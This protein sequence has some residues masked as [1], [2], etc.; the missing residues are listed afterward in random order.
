MTISK[1][2]F[3]WIF[4]FFLAFIGCE[5][6]DPKSDEALITSF[7]LSSVSATIAGEA[8]TLSVPYGTDISSLSPSIQNSTAS[9]ITPA[10]ATARNFGSP[11][12]YTVTA[13]D[14][15]TTNTYTVTVTVLDP[16]SVAISTFSIPDTNTQIDESAKTI[17]VSVFE[18]TD[19]S[20]LSPVI[21]TI[22]TD[23]TVMGGAILDL[24]SGP[25]TITVS[26]GSKSENYTVSVK[27]LS[28]GFDAENPVT[29]IDA[30]AA[31]NS[32]PTE[33]GDKGDNE[34]GFSINSQHVYVADKGEGVI[35]Y[36][37]LDGSSASASQLKNSDI[38]SGG[39]F[40]LA[41]VVATENGILASNMNW[42]GGE[43]KVYRWKDHDADPE[44]LL[45]FP[46]KD[47]SGNNIRLGDNINFIDDP[48]GDGHLTAM[49][50]P[51]FNSIPNSTFVY[52]WDVENG[53]ITNAEKPH[54]IEF[55]ELNNAGSYGYVESV[56]GT[57]NDEYL[58]VN[59]ANIVPTLYDLDGTQKLTSIQSDAIANRTF[60]G[61]V[62]EFNQKRYLAVA[63]AG[64]E[65]AN[66]RD[67]SI[68]IYDVTGDNLVEAFN[69]I[70]P[71]TVGSK[72]VFTHSFGQN[73]NGNQAADIDV[74]VDP[75]GER[76]VVMGGAANNGFQVIELL[77]AK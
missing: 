44:L 60:G 47:S 72:L 37:N 53:S 16:D 50:F 25:V 64:T 1:K 43:F 17:A 52:I 8:I 23:A 24:S 67:A 71:D 14:G 18:G 26:A 42:A 40:K 55:T 27:F 41:D 36:W 68:L 10:A 62:F 74:Y 3:G 59:G 69:A 65:G 2:L 49:V 6:D 13:E 33:L 58:L 77:K 15:K 34:R 4:A 76:V 48:L 21:N 57:N 28:T 7:T 75:N 45:S 19:V 46:T 11:V 30:G 32:L 20:A 56:E 38:V 73:L 35:H 63:T 5:K 29:L 70:D 54:K 51:G 12:T 9:T 61:K 31:S 22:P 39:V 66:I